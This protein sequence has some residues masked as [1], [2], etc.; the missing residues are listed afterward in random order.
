MM[1]LH[2]ACVLGGVRFSQWNL[3]SVR[4]TGEVYLVD[5]YEVYLPV[6]QQAIFD[7]VPY[8]KSL[9]SAVQWAATKMEV[10]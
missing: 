9:A 10:K 8:C 1:R 4:R 5:G 6:E 2:A 7:R 3:P